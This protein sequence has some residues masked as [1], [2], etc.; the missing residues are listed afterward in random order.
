MLRRISILTLFSLTAAL[1]V[2]AT[3]KA[4]R[5]PERDVDAAPYYRH[6][7]L[8]GESLKLNAD[9]FATLDR[10]AFDSDDSDFKNG[11][12]EFSSSVPNTAEW[13]WW[14][15]HSD[16]NEFGND[17]VVG[18]P[19]PASLFLLGSGLLA[20]GMWHRRVNYSARIS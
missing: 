6:D 10:K 11:Q 18:A 4:D 14:L 19:E 7:V 16:Y 3:A 9:R 8:I 17:Q 20:L 1:L 13:I 2:T 12:H 5:M 15:N